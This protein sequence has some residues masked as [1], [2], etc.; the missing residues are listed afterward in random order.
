MY[1]DLPSFLIN[2]QP[3]LLTVDHDNFED[4]KKTIV[5]IAAVNGLSDQEIQQIKT[6]LNGLAEVVEL[7][8]DS[9]NAFGLSLQEYAKPQMFPKRN[10]FDERHNLL[11]RKRW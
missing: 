8:A 6:A 5:M 10:G 1:L 7:T 3:D 2:K 4:L 11:N 9:F